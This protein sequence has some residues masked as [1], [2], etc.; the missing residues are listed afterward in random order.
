M[1]KVA[2]IL[3]LSVYG[4]SIFGIGISKFYCCSKLKSISF[5]FAE[6]HKQDCKVNNIDSDC[7]QKKTQY[8]K[9]KDAHKASADNIFSP[10]SFPLS[11]A[12]YPST[13]NLLVNLQQVHL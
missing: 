1:K 10:K 13:Q 6:S 8:L 5:S 4:L 11:D 12:I 3:L 2:L 9:V 7:C